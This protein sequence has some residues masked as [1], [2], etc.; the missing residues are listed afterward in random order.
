MSF[1]KEYLKQNVRVILY[2]FLFS[3]IFLISFILYHLPI[4]AVL[5]PIFMCALLGMFFFISGFRQ[6]YNRHQQLLEIQKLSAE[7]ISDFPE[8]QNTNDS[9]YQEIIKLLCEQQMQLASQ[10]NDKYSDMTEYYT[11]WAHQIKTPIASMKL[12]LQNEDTALARSLSSELFRIEQYVEMVMTF[13][14]LDSDSTDY[15][16]KKCDLDLIIRQAV[17]NFSGEFIT[18]KLKLEYEPLNTTVITDEKWLT[19]VIE[20]LLSNALKYTTK[21]TIT[22]KL[23]EPKTLCICDT[24]MGIAPEDLPRIFEKGYTGYNGRRDKK[25]SGIGLY[26]CKRVLTKLGHSISVWSKP[27]EGTVMRIDLEQ[28]AVK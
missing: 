23:E 19:F 1:F 27:D 2:F 17:K 12:Q 24:G 28:Y 22:I 20:Q 3:I 18:R 6:A 5:Y 21:G 25:A 15:T 10:M 9:D 26:L 11:I 7:L 14:R 8:P 4:N 16:F 13:L